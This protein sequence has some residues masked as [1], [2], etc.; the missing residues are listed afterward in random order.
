MKELSA[1]FRI[2]TSTVEV[3]RALTDSFI[4]ELWTGYP[5]IMK[6]AE[7]SE[8]ELWDGDICGMNIELIENK[9][10]VQ[11]WYFGETL[12]KSIVTMVLKPKGKATVIEL[13]HANIP[14]DAFD[15]IKSGW[16]EIYFKSLQEF[17]K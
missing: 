17:Y 10:I 5:A 3:F 1:K 7:G 13:T 6:A 11:E 14:D 9:K 4:L 12:E 8:F 15:N 2:N 16:Y